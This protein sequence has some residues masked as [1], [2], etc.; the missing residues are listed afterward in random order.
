[1]MQRN[2]RQSSVKN[3][4]NK[5]K[6]AY[7][8]A[9]AAAAIETM[10]KPEAR[11]ANDWK[12]PATARVPTGSESITSSPMLRTINAAHSRAL[13]KNQ[14][15]GIDEQEW[16]TYVKKTNAATRNHVTCDGKR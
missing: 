13:T 2:L 8:N 3:L 16:T 12:S 4:L 15:D 9:G 6:R 11:V 5:M 14:M 10:E 7:W 1:M